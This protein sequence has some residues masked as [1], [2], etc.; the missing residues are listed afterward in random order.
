M[1]SCNKCNG[2]LHVS[3]MPYYQ[4]PKCG[5]CFCNPCA[6]ATGRGHRSAKVACPYCKIDIRT[7]RTY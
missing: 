5:K 6:L 4:C 2:P 1:S 7:G 3:G